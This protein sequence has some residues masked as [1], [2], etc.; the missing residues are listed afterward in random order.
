MTICKLKEIFLWTF[1]FE[2]L[3]LDLIVR[4]IAT[5]FILML[6]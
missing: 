1:D 5:M 2:N 3:E 4:I 6:A